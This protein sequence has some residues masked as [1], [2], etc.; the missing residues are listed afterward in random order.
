MFSLASTVVG[1]ALAVLAPVT[2]FAQTTADCGA[3][4]SRTKQFPPLSIDVLR[5]DGTLVSK[6]TNIEFTMIEARTH[7]CNLA[8]SFALGFNV[9]S[10]W[11]ASREGSASAIVDMS[12]YS[13]GRAIRR[14]VHQIW[15][16]LS[17]CGQFE[18]PAQT[19]RG[20]ENLIDIVDEIRLSSSLFPSSTLVNCF[21]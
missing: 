6:L 16:S 15:V 13:Q 14:N 18:E 1:L 11:R 7:D 10:Y 3:P 12:F 4:T 2:S 8:T 9:Y 20:L 19:H 21:P 17:F 5:Q